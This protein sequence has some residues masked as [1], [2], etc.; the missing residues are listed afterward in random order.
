MVA[1]DLMLQA[2]P[3]H[4]FNQFG[5]SAGTADAPYGR[6]PDMQACKKKLRA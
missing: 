4:S 3:Q 2:E 1:W 6:Q 5:P